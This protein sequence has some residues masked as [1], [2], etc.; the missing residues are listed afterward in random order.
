LAHYASD[1]RKVPK[2][3]TT[4]MIR[5]KYENNYFIM[6]KLYIFLA[7]LASFMLQ[8]CQD[9]PTPGGTLTTTAEY[10]LSGRISYAV[11]FATPMSSYVEEALKTRCS[12]IAPNYE[13]AD[14][15]AISSN[16]MGANKEL[17]EKAWKEGK[18]IWEVEPVPATHFNF[19]NSIG[20]TP[21]MEDSETVTPLILAISRYSAYSVVN[22]F[23]FEGSGDNNSDVVVSPEPDGD[24]TTKTDEFHLPYDESETIIIPKAKTSEYVNT[25]LADFVEWVNGIENA[26]L[27]D[28]EETTPTLQQLLAND[29]Y[30]QTIP[31]NTI[32]V[33]ADGFEISQVAGSDTDRVTR[34]S[35]ID[36]ELK[37]LPAYQYSDKGNSAGDYYLITTKF[38]T[39]SRPLYGWYAKW[40]G[41]IPVRA[42]AFYGKCMEWTVTLLDSNGKEIPSEKISFFQE[43]SPSTT[44]SGK[45]YS[46]GF[47]RGFNFGGNIGYTMG[48]AGGFNATGSFTWTSS[49]T[50]TINDQS[51]EMYTGTSN[52][53]VT[54][55]YVI[56]NIQMEDD[57]NKAIPAIGRTDQV[58]YGNWVWHVKTSDNDTSTFFKVRFKLRPIYG[59]ENRR[60]TWKHQGWQHE[61]D[62]LLNSNYAERTFTLKRPD[63]TPYGYIALKN[64]TKYYVDSIRFISVDA[65][66][67]KAYNVVKAE[68]DEKNKK[69]TF[70]APQGTYN[71]IF[72][73][74][75]GDKQRSEALVGRY[76]IRDLDVEMSDTTNTST[77]NA[78]KY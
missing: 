12:I 43:P 65:K 20:V 32:S 24:P 21:F 46:K 73:L 59:Y 35:T 60:N 64:T 31:Y 29:A 57:V 33:G 37:S 36:F 54:Y 53:S 48:L 74:Y 75:D 9:E 44:S 22:P 69:T 58:C 10:D 7:V 23:L 71:V 68:V 25:L 77:L 1:S 15:I 28:Y 63:R 3:V 34:W 18:M 47:S 39:H 38:T 2:L 30:S 40:H 8:A 78:E 49:E 4:R 6:R 11:Y 19:W 50:E 26:K 76:I 61:V 51:I 72:G 14:I 17:V 67:P 45:T 27:F 55:K 16:A 41:A 62:K 66:D 56:N 5:V 70:K 13:Q 52:R 42:H